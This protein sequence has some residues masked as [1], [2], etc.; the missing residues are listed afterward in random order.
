M[1]KTALVI[2]PGRGTYNAAELGYLHHYH[3]AETDFISRL[4][5]L[6]TT[7]KQ[8]SISA[9]DKAQNFKPSQ[10]MTGD[11]ASLL[12]Y[13]CALADFQ[14][15]DR[16][17]IDIVAVT[18]NSMGWYLALAAAN[19]LS[20]EDGARLVNTMGTIMHEHAVGGQIVYPLIDENWVISP[21]KKNL[22]VNIL[23][24]KPSGAF[25]ETS[26]HL[27]GLIV[28]AADKTGLS[29]LQKSLPKQ[30]PYPLRLAHH[31]A[32]HSA[33]LGDIIPMAQKALPRNMFKSPD[34]PMIDGHGQI[35]I[36]RASDID[37][38]YAYTLGAQINTAFNFSKAVEVGIKEFAPDMV[39]ILG[40]GST[41]GG[42]TA[43]EL[44]KHRW[45]GLESKA[46]FKQRQSDSPFIISMNIDEQRERIT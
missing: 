46:D 41:L 34:I 33:L 37:A 11:N 23:D 38:L 44:I 17:K 13:A 12:I 29:Y 32:F 39:I 10:H 21:E 9:L 1:K 28:F 31:G 45:V 35:W 4:D 16:E 5:E 22:I 43:Q 26:I 3:A 2:C 42:P 19:A 14:T 30:S 6:R 25:I 40:P 36:P 15:I 27:G 7:H 24:N 8:V 20:L 18:G